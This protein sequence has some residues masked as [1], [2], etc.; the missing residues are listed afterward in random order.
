MILRSSFTSHNE[1]SKNSLG[2]ICAPFEHALIHQLQL[3]LN[4]KWW[5]WWHNEYK[6]G[7]FLA[8]LIK[9]F[10]LIL[11]VSL[12]L[13]LHHKTTENCVAT[14]LYFIF[15][16][17]KRFVLSPDKS[18]KWKKIVFMKVKI[19]KFIFYNFRDWKVIN[20]VDK[21]HLRTFDFELERFKAERLCKIFLRFKIPPRR[22]LK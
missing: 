18:I 19:S 1:L 3:R 22:K 10:P 20:C 9:K 13:F 2:R 11:V 14:F 4:F 17:D 7:L 5:F 16:V 8:D 21:I 12:K 6:W 15:F